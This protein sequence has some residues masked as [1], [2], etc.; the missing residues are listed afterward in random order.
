MQKFLALL[1]ELLF[2]F[3]ISVTA[4]ATP[5]ELVANGEFETQE[6]TG[7]WTHIDERMRTC[8]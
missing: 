6:F 5:I 8:Y 3:A 1:T 4:S 7:D 2:S